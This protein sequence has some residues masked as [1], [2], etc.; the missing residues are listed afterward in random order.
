MSELEKRLARALA[1]CTFLPGTKVKRFARQMAAMADM[2]NRGISDKQK[3]FL[4]E[5]VY[6]FRRQI[7][8]RLVTKACAYKEVLLLAKSGVL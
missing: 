2:E 4:C 7:D 6:T 3:M 5:A 1:A 8:A